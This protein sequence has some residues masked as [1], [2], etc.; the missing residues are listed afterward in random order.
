MG[1]VVVG[2]RLTVIRVDE[3]LN[4]C[5][6]EGMAIFFVDTLLN[7][8]VIDTEK[9]WVL[10]SW[11]KIIEKFGK[12]MSQLAYPIFCEYGFECWVF[13][14]FLEISQRIV[15]QQFCRFGEGGPTALKVLD[16]S[17]LGTGFGSSFPADTEHEEV[18]VK[19]E[20]ELHCLAV[21][22]QH[23]YGHELAETREKGVTAAV[24]EGLDDGGG[25]SRSSCLKDSMALLLGLKSFAFS[26]Q[27][28][29]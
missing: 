17:L 5:V 15:L 21:P 16:E 26:R 20:L 12:L 22:V 19:G 29:W 18:D 9:Q 24:I 1:I 25:T 14:G 10:V 28:R 4:L 23:G 7:E 6:N 2:L 27:S 8:F 11:V 13:V 3:L